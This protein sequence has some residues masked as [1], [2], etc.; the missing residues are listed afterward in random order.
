MS[1]SRSHD[2]SESNMGEDHSSGFSQI[3]PSDLQPH[4]PTSHGATTPMCC[5]VSRK[6][7]R[8]TDKKRNK[9]GAW[10]LFHVVDGL[11]LDVP[12]MKFEP[13]LAERVVQGK[14]D[15]V[16]YVHIT[17]DERKIPRFIR[18]DASVDGEI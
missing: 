10:K 17:Y 4:K 7:Y 14:P 6:H 18:L 15:N 1:D 3:A 9:G 16:Y 5:P 12:L 8:P 2:E 11:K 13:S